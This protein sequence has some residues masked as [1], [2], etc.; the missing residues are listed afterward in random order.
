MLILGVQQHLTSWELARILPGQ[1]PLIPLPRPP[2]Q[3]EHTCTEWL[4]QAIGFVISMPLNA[5][6]LALDLTSALSSSLVRSDS[7]SPSNSEPTWKL[8][9]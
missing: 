9:L 4:L 2:Q 1:P 3:L 5:G 7:G 8:P 6:D